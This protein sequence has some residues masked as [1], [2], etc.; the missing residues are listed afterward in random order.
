M[1][2]LAVGCER[3]RGIKISSLFW[4]EQ[5]RVRWLKMAGG[6]R[7]FCFGYVCE[8]AENSALVKWCLIVSHRQ[9]WVK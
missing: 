9:S 8:D 4:P 7:E 6:N 1:K 5:A 2:A 3:K